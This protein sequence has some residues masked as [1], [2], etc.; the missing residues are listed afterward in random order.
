MPT[1]IF[2]KI[3]TFSLF[4][5]IYLPLRGSNFRIKKLILSLVQLFLSLFIL[6]T[7]CFFIMHVLPGDPF[8]EEH[9]IPDEI[10]ASIRHAWGLDQSIPVQFFCYLK[11]LFHGNLGYSMR[12]PSESV[13]HIIATS[14][15]VSL[16]IGLQS[17]LIALPLGCFL[18][19]WSAKNHNGPLDTIITLFSTCGISIPS[20]VTASLIQLLFIQFLPSLSTQF[21]KN[22]FYSLLP[23]LTLA[24]GPS[25]S[26][27]R[28][29]RSSVLDVLC[30]EY[31]TTARMKG[32]SE[33]RVFT[34]HVI[35]NAILP[36]LQYIGPTC[37]NI[38]V[39]SF[40]IERVFGLPGLGQWFIGG[41]LSRDYPIIGGLTL[42]YSLTLF[43]V[44]FCISCISSFIDP[45][46]DE[47][48]AKI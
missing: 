34:V 10:L 11:Q 14:A 26:I 4:L 41:V 20:F 6:I 37:T 23:S 18:G 38:L 45:R 17:L 5:S 16:Y 3:K 7:I 44:H 28:L 9:G 13:F 29:M 19:T 36:I 31:I 15:P 30:Q 33:F 46:K 27:A 24:I 39:G 35:P 8:Q 42:F 47:S 2:S 12:Y 40:V 25:C 48:R 32:L 22:I 21:S 43:S 1:S